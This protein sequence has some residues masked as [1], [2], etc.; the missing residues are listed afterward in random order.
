MSHRPPKSEREQWQQTLAPKCID[1]RFIADNVLCLLPEMNDRLAATRVSAAI[2]RA[3]LTDRITIR[4][5]P[6]GSRALYAK[7]YYDGDFGHLVYRWQRY[8]WENGFG[9]GSM[10]QV[11]EPLGYVAQERMLLMRAASGLPVS[12]LILAGSLE[13]AKRLMRVSALWLAKFHKVPVP[14]L[15]VES[16][17][18]RMEILK[19]S[20]LLAK[21]AAACPER[22]SQLI[23]LVHQWK[24][25]SLISN[26]SPKLVTMH[27]QFRPAHVF[28]QREAVVAIDLDKLTFSDPAKDVARFAHSMTKSC[29][30]VG[31]DLSR[32]A[33]LAEEFISAYDA[34]APGHLANLRYYMS[35]YSLKQLGK[36]WKNKKS[37]D[38]DK[39][40]FGQMHLA[41]F[42]KWA[43]ASSRVT[44]AA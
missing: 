11:P 17:C 3:R 43:Q 10:V 8:L 40:A 1:P 14:D 22:T 33:V 30:E 34:H 36:V 27:G 29:M 37:D 6:D 5:Q 19:T 26:F 23:D 18:E 24:E 31:G 15:P 4:Y 13:Q 28:V 44:S 12:D 20:A 25:L 38:T 21:V 7:A 9:S 35:L 41:G 32:V 39:A 16:P 2:V 42:Q